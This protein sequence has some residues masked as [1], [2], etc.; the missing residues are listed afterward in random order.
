MN[1]LAGGVEWNGVDGVGCGTFE[2]LL[3]DTTCMFDVVV[4]CAS[5]ATIHMG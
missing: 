5:A 1:G 3:V 2:C 4:L